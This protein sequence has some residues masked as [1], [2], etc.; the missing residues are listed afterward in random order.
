MHACMYVCMHVWVGEIRYL[1]NCLRFFGGDKY[2]IATS[3]KMK[4]VIY[5]M[6]DLFAFQ[7]RCV[8][9]ALIIWQRYGSSIF[10]L[11]TLLLETCWTRIVFKTRKT[12]ITQIHR[13]IW[14]L[15]KRIKVVD[16][17]IFEK[18][19][20][21]NIWISRHKLVRHPIRIARQICPAM[22]NCTTN[23]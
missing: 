14:F 6:F 21:A 15:C 20:T 12:Q 2:T 19:R 18:Q 23:I 1:Y 13:A 8:P 5:H 7:W 3:P 11:F 10:V 22:A 4:L 17:H 9:T 16:R